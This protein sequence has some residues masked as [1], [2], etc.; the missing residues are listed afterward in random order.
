MWDHLSSSLIGT[1]ANQTFN[2]YHG[3]GSNGKSILTDMMAAGLGDYKGTVPITI[4]TEKRPG[5][6]NASSEIMA[7][8]GLRYAVMQ[9]PSKE[10]KLNEGVMKELTGGDAVQGRQLYQESETFE[11]Q[12][13]LTVCTNNLFD[14]NSND[15]GTWRRIRKVDFISKF[16]DT[17]LE[18]KDKH[19]Y[20][21]D[22]NLKEKLPFMAETF[23][24]MLVKIAF[25]NK[26]IVKDCDYV[27]KSTI[28]YRMS[29][30]HIADFVSKRITKDI[31]DVIKKGLLSEEFRRFFKDGQGKRNMPRGVELYSYITEKTGVV[32]KNGKFKGLHLFIPEEEDNDDD[33][34]D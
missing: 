8:K 21:K 11:P 28:D 23:V 22:L 34:E 9:E 32:E 13:T 19:V 17:E 20:L 26:G 1:N 7:L 29:Q 18:I 27:L 3:S 33:E 10:V 25:E 30:D 6:G 15:D 14:V 4:V 5:V 16:V 31:N 2:I 24:S 12:F